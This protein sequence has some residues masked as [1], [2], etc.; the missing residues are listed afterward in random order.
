LVSPSSGPVK[1]RLL[2]RKREKKKNLPRGGHTPG[3]SI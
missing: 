2:G 1:K 3:A